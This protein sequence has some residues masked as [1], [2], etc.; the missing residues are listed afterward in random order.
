MPGISLGACV[1]TL[2]EWLA[3][4]RSM[5]RIYK[6]YVICTGL[7]GAEGKGFE[8]FW[9]GHQLRQPDTDVIANSTPWVP[10]HG[11]CSQSAKRTLDHQYA[12][13]TIHSGSGIPLPQQK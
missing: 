1:C 4:P 6:T 2:V 7:C 5:I 12:P 11:R 9:S 8:P 10:L 3:R 13:K